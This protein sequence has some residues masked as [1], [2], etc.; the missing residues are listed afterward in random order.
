MQTKRPF[1]MLLF[2]CA[3]GA[4]GSAGAARAAQSELEQTLQRSLS[5]D[6]GSGQRLAP[7]GQALK[8]FIAGGYV[9]RKPDDRYDYT[10]YRVLRKPAQFL[11]FTI[12]VIEEEYMAKYVGCCVSP[13][14]G[15]VLAGKG[16]PGRLA[17]FARENG[18]S[19]E[20]PI[21]PSTIPA[22]VK[23]PAAAGRLTYLSCR[24]RDVTK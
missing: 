14:I 5:L 1:A 8:A 7:S 15:L 6:R 4:L 18:C 23:M 10:D 16:D 12:V 17:A 2:C 22:D 19:L 24:E 20:A 9:G 13:G 11:G 21:D 3:L